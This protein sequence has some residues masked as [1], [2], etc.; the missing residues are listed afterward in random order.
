MGLRWCRREAA[1]ASPCCRDYILANEG[2]DF[3]GEREEY[4][5]LVLDR[6]QILSF[7]REK[8]VR[9]IF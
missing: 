2:L 3:G 4:G 7:Q 5:S 1:R 6:R 9:L 8:V